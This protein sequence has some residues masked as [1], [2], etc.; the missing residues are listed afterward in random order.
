MRSTAVCVALACV[1]A[2]ALVSATPLDDY[3]N[4][5]D[6]N[7]KFIDTGVRRSGNG[8]TGYVYNL[9]SQM[10]LSEANVSRP[11]WWHWLIIIIPH[12]V[13]MNGTKALLYITGNDNRD[14][15]EHS[16]PKDDDED[17]FVTATLAVSA[18]TPAAVLFQVPNQP[19]KFPVDPFHSERVEDA[20]IALTVVVLHPEPDPARMDSRAPNDE[21]WC[22]G[23]R[24]HVCHHS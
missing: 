21:G 2:G 4:K 13:K 23:P 19:L 5:P 12:D 15:S 17:L 20:A 14:G 10:W 22:E 1:I 9:T 24:C 8:W 3:V 16:I 11:L 18:R 6:P 7:F